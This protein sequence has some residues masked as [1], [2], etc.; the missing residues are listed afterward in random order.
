MLVPK[1]TIE[2][3]VDLQRGKDDERQR[4]SKG[5]SRYVAS[6]QKE[7]IIESIIKKRAT[8]QEN[9]ADPAMRGVAARNTG[10]CRRD[11][12]CRGTAY[13]I[14]IAYADP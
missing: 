7:I 11:E 12:S 2:R 14:S 4:A 8:G 6:N 10:S 9:E 13:I 3:M 5:A 1:Q